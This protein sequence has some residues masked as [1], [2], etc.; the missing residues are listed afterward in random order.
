MFL[1]SKRLNYLGGPVKLPLPVE[2]ADWVTDVSIR[3]LQQF[4]K[5]LVFSVKAV[6]FQF[7]NTW[8]AQQKN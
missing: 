6:V 1:P 2:T 5:E 7:Q 3:W 8:F 4:F